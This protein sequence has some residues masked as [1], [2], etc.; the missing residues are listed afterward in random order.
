MELV[1]TEELSLETLQHI[2]KDLTRINIELKKEQLKL[3]VKLEAME[4]ESPQ[5]QIT[6]WMEQ[7][8]IECD[9]MTDKK[10][11]HYAP[12][13]LDTLYDNY[14]EWCQEEKSFGYLVTVTDKKTFKTEL[15]KWQE[16]S[17]YGLSIAK[18]KKDSEGYPN[19]YL[20]HPL[21]N[22]KII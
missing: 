11:M 1:N 22:L 20:S 14:E 6:H 8:C 5:V 15:L 10:G 21:F 3:K 12:T 9:N 13:H 4:S 2:I 18:R 19:G 16:N 7:N 17:K